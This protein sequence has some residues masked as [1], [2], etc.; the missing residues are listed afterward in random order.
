MLCVS[1]I[2]AEAG[3]TKRIQRALRGTIP[4][5]QIDFGE[6]VAV[7]LANAKPQSAKVA[8]WLAAVYNRTRHDGACSRRTGQ[9]AQF[10]NFHPPR[11]ATAQRAQ[12]QDWGGGGDQ[13]SQGRHLS[14]V[15]VAASANKSPV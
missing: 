5:R 1:D 6:S 7:N 13:R 15:A 2:F 14:P 8:V 11:Q 10:W 3:R 9:A 4:L 12:P